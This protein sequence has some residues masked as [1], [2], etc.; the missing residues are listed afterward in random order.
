MEITVL[1][2]ANPCP[3]IERAGTSIHLSVSGDSL[4]V[5]CGP[6]ATYRMVEN[7]INFAAIED[8]FFTHHHADHNA[9][10]NHFVTASWYFGRQNL[11]IYGPKGTDDLVQ[12]Y[13]TAYERHIED[14]AE[15]RDKN[16]KGLTDFDIVDVTPEFEH[17][18]DG[19]IV[20]AIPVEHAY[21]AIDVYAYRFTETNTGKTFVFSGD[22]KPLD[23]MVRFSTNADVLVHECN[24][25]GETETP[26]EPGGVHERYGNAPFSDYFDWVFGDDTQ[27]ELTDQLHTMPSEAGRIAAAAGVEKLVLTHLNPLRNPVDIRQAAKA[28]FDGVVQVAEDGMELSL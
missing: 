23:S 26:L 14:I 12:G 11:S 19:W 24:V 28:E 21:K 1:G 3:G 17:H 6:W 10:F 15:W 27:E 25:T 13:L 4:L 18:G 8:L 22:T 7:N 2:T 16:T 20:E 9:S 5:D